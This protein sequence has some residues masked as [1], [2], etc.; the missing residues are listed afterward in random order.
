M[1]NMSY[2]R[3]QNT[4]ND[5]SDCEDAMEAIINGDD[6]ALGEDELRAAK[7]L[8]KTAANMLQV[9]ADAAGVTVEE[10]VDNERYID[11]AVEMHLKHV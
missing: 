3:F 2:C 9:L 10:L 11:D 8:L 5:L 6:D 1:S 4:A 7:R